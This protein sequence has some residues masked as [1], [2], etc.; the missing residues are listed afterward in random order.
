MKKASLFLIAFLFFT[1]QHLSA[2]T[3]VPPT[4]MEEQLEKLNSLLK[5]IDFYYVDSVDS[6]EI[7]EHAIVGLLEHLD[8][9]SVYIPKEDLARMNEPLI[10]NFEGIGIRFQIVRDTIVVV[11]PISG[12]PSE[13]LGIRSGD[14][15]IRIEEELVAGTKITNS[16]VM[17]KLR[18]KKGT[19]VNVS[20]WRK[21]NKELKDYIIVRDKI[22]LY[23]VDASYMATPE[24]GYIKVNRFARTTDAEF[25]EHLEELKKEGLQHLILDLRGNGGGYLETAFK[26]ADEFLEGN[27]MIVYTK[28]LKH[29][30]QEYH[31]SNKGNFLKGKLVILMDEGS[32]SASEIV[33][34]AIQ[35]WDRGLIIGR[36]SFGKGLVQKPY[37]LPDGSAVRLTTARYYTPSGRCIQRPYDEGKK[38]YYE[39]LAD[40]VES[41]EL[42]M[43]DSVKFPDS[44]QYRTQANRIVYGGG[45]IMPDIFIPLD[46][47]GYTDYYGELVRKGMFS[48]FILTYLDRERKSFTETYPDFDQFEKEFDSSD[49]MFDRFIAYA[50]KNGVEKNEEQSLVSEELINLQLK[51]LLAQNIWGSSAYYEVINTKNESYLEAVESIKGDAFSRSGLSYK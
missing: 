29:R 25:R 37:Y 22:P 30:Q 7:V 35:D 36:K 6:E 50:E 39:E 32:A 41:G 4:E 5:T 24:I 44:L 14:K 28:G 47:Q 40:R 46:T 10:G 12:G 38:A 43:A 27:K 31:A 42:F 15:I 19:K 45:G 2:Q 51:A 13:K 33:A 20:I 48:D 23:S 1:F 26:L 49:K 3:T 8:P 9:H 16:D 18:G 34:G 11:S 17:E 21:G